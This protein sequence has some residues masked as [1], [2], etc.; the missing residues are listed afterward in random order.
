MSVR[1]VC[2]FFRPDRSCY[3]DTSWTAWAVWVK[4]YSKYSLAPTDE[5]ISLRRSKVKVTS[6]RQDG[7]SIHIGEVH[8]PDVARYGWL[9]KCFSVC[10][11]ATY[12]LVT[13]SWFTRGP[14][15][16][17]GS[18]TAAKS[19]NFSLFCA[20]WNHFICHTQV[21]RLHVMQF[22]CRHLRLMLKLPQ[23]WTCWFLDI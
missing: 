8:F 3:H 10:R 14:R 9:W 13:T 17:N 2:P 15:R 16:W 21:C 19:G 1:R 11:N 18:K 4:L 12:V 20:K 5:L 7:D 6:G 23:S 22:V